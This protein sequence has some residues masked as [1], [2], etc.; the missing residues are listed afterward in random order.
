MKVRLVWITPEAE[1]IIGYCARVSNPANQD[2]P[3]VS[4]LLAY[5]IKNKHWSIFEMAAATFEIETTRGISPQILRHKS[6][7]FQEFCVAGDTEIYFDLPG[8]V[9]RGK[10]QLYKKRISDLNRMWKKNSYTRSSVS[11]MFVRIYDEN[12]KLFSHA[13]IKHIMETGDKQIFEIELA[14]GKKIKTTKE[15]KFLTEKGFVPLEEAIGLRVYNNTATMSKECFVATNGVPAYQNAEWLESAKKRLGDVT[16]ISMEAGCSYHTIR[17]WLRI[18]GL[19]F[20]RKEIA[21]NHQIWNKGKFGY[22]T[23]MVVSEKHKDA[24]RAARSGS[25]SN[26]W[27]GGVL[28][29]FRQKVWDFTHAA[30]PEIHKKN[31][32]TCQNC[33][34]VGGQLHVHHKKSVSEFPDFAFDKKNLTTLCKKCHYLLH[35]LNGDFKKWKEKSVGNKMVVRWEK[36]SKITYLGVQPTY[37]LEIDHSSHNYVANN[38]VVHNSLRYAEAIGIEKVEARRQDLKDRQNST[39][40]LPEDVQK[41]WEEKTEQHFKNCSSLYEEALAKGIAKESARFVLPMATATRL[42]MNGTVRSWIHYL[43]LRTGNGTQKEHKDIANEIKNIL[44]TEL[45]IVSKALNWI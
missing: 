30:A 7:S 42:Y 23:G 40:D 17:K 41:W 29:S 28:R 21:K 44:K 13:H 33:G 9:S 6:F 1:K 11:K 16:L 12:T 24:I 10:R 4:K 3:D 20:T 37:D 38:I 8:A 39:P 26:L 18:H 27:K 19:Q 36:I 45:P 43:E 32:Y 35:G 2:N 25:K 22:K 14:S 31:N 15:H 34:Q 5:C